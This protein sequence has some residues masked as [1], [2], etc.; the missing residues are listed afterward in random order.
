LLAT[1]VAACSSSSGTPNDAGA[2]VASD[3]DQPPSWQVALS[4]LDG[5]LLSVWGSSP[6]DVYAVG[7][8]R[9][10]GF[11]T[12]VVHFDGTTWKRFSPGGMETYWWV[13]GASKNDVWMVGEN[14]RI[15]HWDG[16][17][18][19]EHS[20]GTTATL[21]GVWASGAN[22]AWAVG[23]TANGGKNAPNDIVLHWDGA[24]WTPSPMPQLFGR[25]YFKVWGSS[26]DDVYVVGEAA[27]IWHRKNGAFAL[28][29]NPAQGTLTTVHG[30]GAS[31]IYAVGG[32]D[33]LRS[34]GAT[35]TRVNVTLLNDVNGVGC[36]PSGAAAIVGGGGLKQRLANGAWI[37]DFALDPHTDLHG[38]W[39][40]GAGDYWA[41]GGNFVSAAAPG[42]SRQ[43]VIARYGRG[44]VATA[45]SP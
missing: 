18:F 24:A 35:W 39:A 40:D 44:S 32:R 3:A 30:C 12:L 17:S 15:T 19:V 13:Y 36:G 25:A 11:P 2:D 29:T 1:L 14:G 16:S 42:V 27:T 4:G 9:G 5:A 37:D 34:D 38:A 20:S 10:N 6:S 28:E 31:E 21:Y 43:G 45:L 33:V 41:V 22:D 7:G 26:A 23:G 8:A